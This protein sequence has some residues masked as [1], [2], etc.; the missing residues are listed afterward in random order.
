MCVR[1]SQGGGNGKIRPDKNCKDEPA[2]AES[3]K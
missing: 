2:E 3:D 1:E